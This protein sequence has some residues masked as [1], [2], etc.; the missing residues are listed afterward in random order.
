MITVLAGVNGAGKSSVLGTAIRNAGGEYFNPDEATQN[1]LKENPSMTLGDANSAAWKMGFIL[2]S[3]AVDNDTDFIFETTLGGNS[4]FRELMRA[5]ELGREVRILFCGL[6][7][8]EL[9]LARVAARVKAGG[10]DIPEEKIRE[11]YVNSIANV[12]DLLPLCA[13]VRVFDNSAPISNGRPSAY[14]VLHIK[15][16]VLIQSPSPDIPEWSKPIAVAAI[17]A[18]RKR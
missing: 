5:G 10:H 18:V 12:R 4:V 3:A 15:A 9:H 13:E 8:V 17:K 16:G 2:L 7:S 1:F 11:R 14:C 6:E